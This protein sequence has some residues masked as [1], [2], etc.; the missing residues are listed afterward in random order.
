MATPSLAHICRIKTVVAVTVVAALYWLSR[1]PE[2]PDDQRHELAAHF[3][4]A[5]SELPEVAGPPQRFVRS[6]HPALS[7]HAAWISAVGAAVAL[8]D[9]DGDGLPNDVCYVDTRT[10]Q[11]IVAPVPGTGRRYAPFVLTPEPL[12]YD[13]STT[14]PMGC[15]LGDFN[16]DGLTDVL[17]YYW[18]RS[19][20][21]FLR[22]GGQATGG[23]APLAR[24]LYAPCELV[25][26]IQRWYTNAATQADLDGDG[27]VDLVIGNYFPDGARVLDSSATDHEVMQGSMSRAFNGGRKRLFLWQGAAGGQAPAAL[28]GEAE[29]VLDE[30]VA[31]GWTLAVG[32]ADLD[33]D[34]LPELYFA[35]DF[36]PDRL[37][38]NRSSPG[39]LRFIL[40]Q[41]ER[42]FTTARSKVLGR[43]SFKGM[44]V[45]FGDLN[46][47]GLLDIFVS[48]I[49][50]TYALTESNFVFLSTGQTWRMREGVAPYRE[51]S[52]E[53]GL[54]RGGWG[55][56]AR[57]GDFDNDGVLEALQASGFL[58]GTT[59]RWPE[60]QEL[61]TANNEV[62]SC[63]G[64][65]PRFRVGDDLSGGNH[66]PFFVRS[67]GGRYFDVAAE[68]GLGEPMVGRGIATADVDGDGRLDFAV[69][70]QWGPS[71]FFRNTA[72][73]P[74]AFLGL[75]LLLPVP[76]E[77]Q[78]ATAAWPGHPGLG[79]RGRPAIGAAATVRL[80]DGRRLT[81][82]V[83]GG[84]GHSGKRSPDLHF[85]LGDLDFAVEVRVDLRWRGP[86]GRPR[87]EVLH[88]TPGWH[89]VLLGSPS[90]PE[91]VDRHE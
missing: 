88:L 71:Y 22:R 10:D 66:N 18:G 41:G 2:L 65:W 25:E 81:A 82:Q 77:S 9:L 51:R 29:G 37:L 53:L 7:R 6:V 13:P 80:P 24:D 15:L 89:T 23:A 78:R 5:R 43:D 55:W 73:H 42:A 54:S 74:G 11:V 58:R 1:P 76:G 19:P 56:E 16:E 36:G 39:R 62:V 3:S 31:C 83:D 72:T 85:G 59:N 91:E 79:V 4:F 63:P 38:H 52:E 49:A 27:H 57:L 12:P 30:E 21:L 20:V 45:D 17:V 60:L 50:D 32:A 48:N 14:A 61:A 84:N 26:P 46:G 47:D 64:A 35:N 70:N 44:G 69:A 33:G 34:L 68:V 90:A 28:F 8:G 67:R 40:L 86:D 75:H 87:S